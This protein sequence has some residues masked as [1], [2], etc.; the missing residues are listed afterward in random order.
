[1]KVLILG[2]ARHGK[3]TLA[4]FLCVNSGLTYTSTSLF[5]AKQIKE[6]IAPY[7]SYES[8]EKCYEDRMNHRPLWFELIKLINLNDP[9]ST[10]KQILSKWDI[11]CGMRSIAEFRASYNLFDR[12]VYISQTT[13][14]EEA[15]NSNEITIVKMK[16][17][18]DLKNVDLVYND[19]SLERLAEQ[20]KTLLLNW[21][22]PWTKDY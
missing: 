9:A 13:G 6:I 3:D 11:Y 17:I 5:L 8:V 20:A 18:M 7:K 15:I 14:P 4:Q 2:H 10:A 1:M 16:A 12:I 21:S 19:L 22:V